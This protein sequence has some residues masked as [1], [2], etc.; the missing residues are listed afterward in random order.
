MKE[1]RLGTIGSGAIVRSILDNVKLTEG[2]R[3]EAVYSRTEEK[4]RSLASDYGVD[5]VY[6]SLEE[7]FSTRRIMCA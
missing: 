5:K 4:G 2:I 3:L 6:T 7:L 1:I